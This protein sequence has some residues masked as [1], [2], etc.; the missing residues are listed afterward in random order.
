M[1][2]PYPD[3][4][5]PRAARE[6]E[7]QLRATYAR[8][9]AA[10][11]TLAA[12]DTEMA[13]LQ[14]RPA[15]QPY[16]IQPPK[17][18]GCRSRCMSADAPSASAFAGGRAAVP[19]LETPMHPVAVG[20]PS[21]AIPKAT[22]SCVAPQTAAG[23]RRRAWRGCRRGRPRR[24]GPRCACACSAAARLPLPPRAVR[25]RPP[26]PRR[27]PGVCAPWPLSCCSGWLHGPV[28]ALGP[29][30]WAT[31]TWA[32]ECRFRGG[33]S[34]SGPRLR[35]QAGARSRPTR[36]CRR[37]GAPTSLTMTAATMK[38]TCAAAACPQ[39]LRCR[40]PPPPPRA[41]CSRRPAQAPGRAPCRRARR[42]RRRAP[43][44]PR[45]RRP[46]LPRRR[47]RRPSRAPGR[48]TL[49]PRRR[50]PRR[51]RGRRRTSRACAPAMSPPQRAPRAGRSRAALRTDRRR[52]RGRRRWRA[53]PRPDTETRRV[54]LWPTR[55]RL[56]RRAL[57]RPPPPHLAQD[58][59]NRN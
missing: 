46:G 14:A 3:P 35:V 34:L 1:Y 17:A 58:F 31:R 41:A 8:I 24:S 37:L 21:G 22:A 47:A 48:R 43:R 20:A 57:V 26:P 52:G 49:C 19:G 39:H 25:A 42:P 54:T 16:P 15:P 55:Q 2:L 27:P 12:R 50:R 44:P 13:E 30:R 28:E 10:D 45:R 18:R 40:L 9:A 5:L 11:A 51:R 32:Q 38:M 23:P 6:A 56:R 36:T 53:R 4:L 7:A 33:R 29:A 59:L